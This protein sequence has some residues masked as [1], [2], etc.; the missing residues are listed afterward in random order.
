MKTPGAVAALLLGLLLP[1]GLAK[2]GPLRIALLADTTVQGDTILLAH[3]LPPT[4]P[5]DLRQH[6]EK[7]FLGR[8]PELGSERDLSQE[9]IRAGLRQAGFSTHEF[10][11]PETVVVRHSGDP[12]TKE[13]VWLALLDAA[14]SRGI[15]LPAQ[16]RSQDIQWAA[17]STLLAGNSRLAV[18]SISIDKLVKQIRFRLRISN[19]PSAPSFYAWCPLP[20][21][22]P[23]PSLETLHAHSPE[24]SQIASPPE[25]APVSIRRPATLHLHSQNSSAVL[26]VRALQSGELGEIVRVRIMGNG[27]TLVARVAGPDF[28]DAVF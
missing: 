25:A 16:L 22:Q 21:G 2:A 3:L 14:A 19:N 9:T 27:H 8:A 7:I 12:L 10:L 13:R 18:Q 11:V 28:L 4:A 23:S 6:A 1:A 5:F 26:Q 17:P 15:A 20:A 24:H